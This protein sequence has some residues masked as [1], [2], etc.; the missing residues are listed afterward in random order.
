M[1]KLLTKWIGRNGSI[2]DELDAEQKKKLADFV[3]IGLEV[4]EE[5]RKIWLKMNLKAMNLI[6]H[7]EDPELEE[8]SD[9]DSIKGSK[10]IYPLL[11]SSVMHGAS[12]LAPHF[13]RNN[14]T[15]EVAVHGDDPT[16]VKFAKAKD[17]G[18][19][20][21]Y[22]L[23]YQ[24]KSW[25]RGCHKLSTMLIC[26]GVAYRRV[27]W[28]DDEEAP[29]FD[30]IP[31]QDLIVNRG[32]ETLDKAPR[33]TIRHYLTD[34]D[35]ICKVRN[36]EFNG[37]DEDEIAKLGG[38]PADLEKNDE[39]ENPRIHIIDEQYCRFDLDGDGYPEPWKLFVHET[40][41]R[42]LAAYPLPHCTP[43]DI[44]YN[45]ANKIRKIPLKH[46]IVDYHG[47]IDD[48]EG[49]FYSLG[50]NYLLLH[51][52]RI[53]NGLNRLLV[54]SGVLSNQQGGFCTEAFKTE[55]RVLRFKKNTFQTVELGP[56]EK[57][58]DQIMLLPFKEPSVVLFNFLDMLINN[59]KELGFITDSM[60][61]DIT[62]QNVPATT[63]L[64]ILE[65]QTRA[66]K[67]LIDKL[68]ISLKLEFEMIF[69]LNYRHLQNTKYIRFLDKTFYVS[70]D[71]FDLSNYDI[72]PVADPTM[73][74]DAHMF[75]RVHGLY[76]LLQLNNPQVNAEKIIQDYVRVMGVEHPE[77]YTI[78]L[79]PPRQGPD[80]TD[81]KVIKVLNDDKHKALDAQIE[82]L[83][84]QRKDRDQERKDEEL[85]LKKL[86]VYNELD[87]TYSERVKTQADAARAWKEAETKERMVDVAEEKVINE[88]YKIGTENRKI[89][90]LDRQ[91]RS[92]PRDK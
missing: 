84:Q 1:N 53:I 61:G 42:L 37:I 14:K 73:S 43:K 57:I 34:Y 3:I 41:K 20:I 64:A 55:D 50:L 52:N 80:M 15:C 60:T 47:P 11:L 58:Q 31:P 90:V 74:S 29:A 38:N 4:D 23:L 45:S 51:P 33:I 77:E 24:N 32:I 13:T 86:K 39:R 79:P 9:S 30:I 81:P 89:D 65:N 75:A 25:K 63:M 36:G 18:S 72:A 59:S 66:F 8:K 67:P 17:T 62:G 7:M 78:P 88:R 56:M 5:S 91:S 54:D 10:V 28:D 44:K 69:D 92:K 83:E 26:W 35:L 76:Q 16:G 6:K 70:R 71:D 19:F 68:Y 12:R 85:D 22:Q 40:D 49:G 21:N 27:W 87:G 48:P 82:L 46:N 2:A